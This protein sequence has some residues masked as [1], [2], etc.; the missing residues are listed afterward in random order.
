MELLLVV[1][2]ILIVASI[3]IPNFIDALHKAKQK[4]TM[5]ELNQIGGA[6]MS[7]ITDQV[8]VA[9]AGAGK[10]YDMTNLQEFSYEQIYNYLHPSE[11]FFYVQELPRRDAWGSSM[12]FWM[13]PALAGDSQIMICA[14]A[15]DDVFD[16]CDGSDTMPVGPFLSTDFDQDII[17][18][19]GILLRWPDAR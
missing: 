8:G 11:T 18:G 10:T 16:T 3:M 4:R 15:R 9:S 14:A 6:W 7:W 13:D 12:S 5:A 19:D 17:W 1:T 2:I